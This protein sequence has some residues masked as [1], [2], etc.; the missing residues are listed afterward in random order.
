MDDNVKIVLSGYCEGC[1]M[2]DIT[3]RWYCYGGA[4]FLD[5]TTVKSELQ[6]FCKNQQLCN[7]WHR[8]LEAAKNSND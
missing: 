4:R 2:A 1:Q 6:A 3:V 5:G 8:K 7:M